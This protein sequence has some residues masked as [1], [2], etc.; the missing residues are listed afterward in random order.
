MLHKRYRYLLDQRVLHILPQE[1]H[2]RT[3]KKVLK[4]LLVCLEFD[5]KQMCMLIFWC[6]ERRNECR[7]VHQTVVV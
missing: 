6:C 2:N 5:L 4:T 1:Y 7:E 3:L